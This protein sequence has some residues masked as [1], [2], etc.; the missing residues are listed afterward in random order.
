MLL[1]LAPEF[2]VLR[3]LFPQAIEFRLKIWL[4]LPRRRDFALELAQPALKPDFVA[5]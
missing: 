3:D 5:Q 4:H 2:D 1:L